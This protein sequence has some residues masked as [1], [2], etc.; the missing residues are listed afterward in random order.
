MEI[1]GG[2]AAGDVFGEDD[3]SGCFDSSF[4]GYWRGSREFVA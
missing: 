1:A 4:G 3:V 2:T